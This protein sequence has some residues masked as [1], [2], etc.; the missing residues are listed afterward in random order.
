MSGR[1]RL[2]AE[3]PPGSRR[4][5][6]FRRLSAG[7]P[8]GTSRRNDWLLIRISWPPGS[9]SAM[10]ASWRSSSRIPLRKRSGNGWT[11]RRGKPRCAGLSPG[12]RCF[13]RFSQLATGP[14]SRYNVPE[15]RMRR[16]R[17]TCLTWSSRRSPAH[18]KRPTGTC[19]CL[20]GREGQLSGNA[21]AT[22]FILAQLDQSPLRV[23]EVPMGDAAI[24]KTGPELE[25]GMSPR[26]YA[27]PMAAKSS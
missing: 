27:L 16:A 15:S 14:C 17:R 26:C 4:G 21:Y 22:Q 10:M 20:D 2:T 12:T 25:A 13:A 9:P 11:W 3:Q 8:P 1:S 7:F 6:R 5:S 18:P 24:R 19:R 23:V